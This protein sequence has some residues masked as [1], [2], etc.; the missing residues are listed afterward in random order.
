MNYAQRGALF[1]VNGAIMVFAFAGAMICLKYN[2]SPVLGVSIGGFI[3]L[4]LPGAVAYPVSRKANLLRI[5]AAVNTNSAMPA[6]QVEEVQ[7]IRG[8][9][10]ILWLSLIAFAWIGSYHI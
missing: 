8:W 6:G 4:M 2:L 10:F 7:N 3:G 9:T 1:I 5:L